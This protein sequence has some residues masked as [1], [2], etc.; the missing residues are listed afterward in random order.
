MEEFEKS[1]LGGRGLLCERRWV[2]GL[3]DRA[4]GLNGW[5]AEE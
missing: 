1:G 3:E 4:E 5:S 2:E